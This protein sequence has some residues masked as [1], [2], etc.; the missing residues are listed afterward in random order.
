[1]GFHL[2]APSKEQHTG[3]VIAELS[4]GEEVGDTGEK[5]CEHEAC[6][7]RG[8]LSLPWLLGYPVSV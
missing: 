5:I 4:A 1:M 7:E 2:L 6:A 3:D 8:V